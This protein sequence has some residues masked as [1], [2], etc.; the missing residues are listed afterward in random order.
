MILLIIAGI[1][2]LSPPRHAE[3]DDVDGLF[4]FIEQVRKTTNK[5][6]GIKMVI[7]NPSEIESIAKKLSEKPNPAPDFIT[8]DGGEGGSGAAPLVIASH[9]GLPM[10]QALAVTNTT[11]QKYGV[12]DYVTLF[13]SGKIAT[14]A[15]VAMVLALG[16]DAVGI[17]R[18]FL[19]SLGCI[20]SLD[21]HAGRCPTGITTHSKSA[22][23]AIDVE[24][25]SRRDLCKSADRR[26]AYDRSV[27]RL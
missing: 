14:Q 1:V 24:A 27:V 20:Q 4:D 10:R 21:C 6:V 18:G 2:A 17:A 7:G 23:K 9:A 16:A 19:L 5:P 25:A 26:N 22:Q 12:R 11:L 15:D 3:F 8:A 13:A